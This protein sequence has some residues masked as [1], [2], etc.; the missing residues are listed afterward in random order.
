MSVWSEAFLGVIAVATLCMALVQVGLVVAAV[1]LARRVSRLA[2]ELET[3]LRPFLV[4]VNAIGRDVSRAVALVA[5]Q[6]ERADKLFADVAAKIEQ[7]L[8]ALQSELIGPL[9]RGRALLAAIRAA[10]EVIRQV[11]PH[12][13]RGRGEDEDALFI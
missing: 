13:R 6:G 12:G 8:G 10:I 3:E 7:T 9:L 5:L 11:R 2:D 4:N 1:R